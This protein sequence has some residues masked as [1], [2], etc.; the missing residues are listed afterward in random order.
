MHKQPLWAIRRA[1]LRSVNI[2]I[3]PPRYTI[4]CRL[5]SNQLII[6]LKESDSMGYITTKDSTRIF[7]KDLGPSDA[8]PIV[9]SHGWPLNSDDWDDQ[10]TFFLAHG[11]RCIAHDRRGHGRSDQPLNGNDMDTYADDLA[12]LLDT[13][14]LKNVVL[15]G[16]ST[17]GGEVTRYLGRHGSARVSKAVLVSAVAPLM[18]QTESNPD[19]LPISV[20]DSF[21]AAMSKDR[22]QFFIDVPSGPFF[23]FNRPNATISQGMIWRWWS[24]GMM[25][26]YHSAYDCIK[27][28]SETDLSNDLEGTEVPV[29][30]LH[31]DDD[32]VVPIGA[33][34][35]R[36]VEMLKKG[37]LV[38]VKGGPHAL[39]TMHTEE[40]NNEILN[41]VSEK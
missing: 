21:R 29:L 8:Q 32:Q 33:S 10:I 17:G 31:G 20:F 18:L 7:Y 14:D 30:V 6:I 36:S 11:Y 2:Y 38:E 22:S 37:R 26:G 34:A 24:M 19:G 23:G 40:V 15:V 3:Y 25:C 41:F 27:A 9:F 16:H 4:E 39:H 12:A 1:A 35:R 13:L 28:F 5:R